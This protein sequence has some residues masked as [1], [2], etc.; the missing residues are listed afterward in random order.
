MELAGASGT[1]RRVLRETLFYVVPFM[2]GALPNTAMKRAMRRHL[3]NVAM[4]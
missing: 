2:N 3:E 1:L 4:Q